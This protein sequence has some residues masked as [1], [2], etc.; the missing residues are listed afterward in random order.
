M[1]LS[2]TVVIVL[3]AI[4]IVALIVVSDR[5]GIA[6]RRG[7]L[8]RAEYARVA[9]LAAVG[10]VERLQSFGGTPRFGTQTLEVDTQTG[11]PMTAQQVAQRLAQAKP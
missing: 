5:T 8:Q 11:Q 2:R 10:I 4:A 3:C 7:D 1:S 9:K 6:A